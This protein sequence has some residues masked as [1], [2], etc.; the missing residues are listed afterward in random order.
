MYKVLW[1][2]GENL[3]E[4]Q[5]N[6]GTSKLWIDVI[7]GNQNTIYGKALKFVAPKV[8]AGKP[9]VEIEH[10]DVESELRFWG[11]SLI[12]YA[13]GVDMSMNVVNNYMIKEWYFVKLPEMF[14][15]EEGFLILKFKT[16]KEREVVM[17]KGPYTIRNMPMIIFKWRPDFSM[18]RDMLRTLPI[19]VKLP[20]LPTHMWGVSS[21]G[22]IGSV[23]RSTLFT[24][25]CTIDKLRVSYARILVDVDVTQKLQEEFDIHYDGCDRIQKVEYE[26]RPKYCEKCQKVGH[27]C[28]V[29][30]KPTVKMWQQI[31]GKGRGERS[32]AN[33]EGTLG[34]HEGPVMIN[35]VSTSTNNNPVDTEATWTVVL[36]GNKEKGS[37][38]VECLNNLFSNNGFS[39]L[40]VW[41]DHKKNDDKNVYI[42]EPRVSD[43][44]LVCITEGEQ[45]PKP[46][47]NF[48]FINATIYL[49]NYNNEVS[50]NWKKSVKGHQFQLLWNKLMRMQ[51]VVRKLQKPLNAKIEWIRKGDGHNSFFHAS[52][53]KKNSQKIISLMYKDNGDICDIPE[54]I[55]KEGFWIFIEGCWGL[56]IPIFWG[57]TLLL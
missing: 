5:G 33:K 1:E 29:E 15:N 34:S 40:E 23:I 57:L 41:Q 54:A 44:A 27:I 16:I 39:T 56:L 46:K 51:Q 17:L 8:V 20:K 6:N 45:G 25:V 19:W 42:I 47:T 18:E 55:E 3:D 7:K 22:K 31:D 37:N 4:T 10:E 53:K 38:N 50:V 49:E 36:K 9:V 13:I 30:K 21:L 24:D 28:N 35:G 48:K 32:L 14:Y 26:W 2:S 52:M 43:H 11:S 12:I